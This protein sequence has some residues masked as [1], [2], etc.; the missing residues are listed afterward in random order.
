[1]NASSESTSFDL[2]EQGRQAIRLFL[3][4]GVKFGLIPGN[5]EIEFVETK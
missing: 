5:H 3:D 4:H 1:M 2:G